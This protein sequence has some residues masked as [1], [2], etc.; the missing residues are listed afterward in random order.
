MYLHEIELKVIP[1]SI[2]VLVAESEYSL[3]GSHCRRLELLSDGV[4]ENMSWVQNRLLGKI[5]NLINV[6]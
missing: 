3:K 5:E 6:E 1:V 4:I 2:S